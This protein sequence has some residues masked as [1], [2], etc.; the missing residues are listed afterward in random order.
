VGGSSPFFCCFDER[1]RK[2][3]K[4]RGRGWK[5]EKRKYFAVELESKI[6]KEII[7][8]CEILLDEEKLRCNQ[9]QKA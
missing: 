3:E 6:K 7:F 4:K 2:E 5:E 1:R 9:K 8:L